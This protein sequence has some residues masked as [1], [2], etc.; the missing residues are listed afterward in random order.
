MRIHFEIYHGE[1][2]Y[3]RGAREFIVRLNVSDTPHS[4]AKLAFAPIYPAG[5]RDDLRRLQ[6]DG[7]G[8]TEVLWRRRA[9]ARGR[10]QRQ[11]SPRRVHDLAVRDISPSITAPLAPR[12]SARRA[13]ELLLYLCICLNAR[14][15]FFFSGFVLS[16]ASLLMRSRESFSGKRKRI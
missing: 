16:R 11:G 9:P 4:I 2:A 13:G 1:K 7:A 12:L 5:S 10:Q 6:H 14:A 15:S 3:K 8:D